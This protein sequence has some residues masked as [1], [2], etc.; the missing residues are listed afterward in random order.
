MMAV[1][2]SQALAAV[3]LA[4]VK[5]ELRIPPTETSHDALLTSQI[6]A[7]AG[8]AAESTG[9]DGD[10]LADLRPAIVSA[11][12]LQYDGLHEVTPNAA[13]NAWLEP[14]RSYSTK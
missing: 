10:D 14:F 12:R 7:A 5:V 13:H 9:R 1:S 6:V 2:E 4:S 11:V 8:F 3:S